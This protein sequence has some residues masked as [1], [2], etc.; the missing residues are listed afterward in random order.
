MTEYN[1][2]SDIPEDSKNLQ[3]CLNKRQSAYVIELGDWGRQLDMI[4]HDFEGWRAKIQEIKERY[5]KPS[6]VA[7]K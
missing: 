2:E 5:P 1:A 3:E 6:V 7:S 4:Y